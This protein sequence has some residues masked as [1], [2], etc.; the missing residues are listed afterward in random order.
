[1]LK[2]NRYKEALVLKG[3]KSISVL[4]KAISTVY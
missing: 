1:V 3:D 4:Y 2:I